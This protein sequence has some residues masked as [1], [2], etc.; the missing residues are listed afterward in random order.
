MTRAHPWTLTVLSASRPWSMLFS[1]LGLPHQLT[2]PSPRLHGHVK[3]Q[4]FPLFQ[5]C[6]PWKLEI[7][8][9]S[10]SNFL[11]CMPALHSPFFSCLPDSLK[12]LRAWDLQTQ[13][14]PVPQPIPAKA[15]RLRTAT[16]WVL[17]ALTSVWRASKDPLFSS[18]PP[19]PTPAPHWLGPW[20]RASAVAYRVS[21]LG[22]S[23]R[24]GP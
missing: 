4:V 8:L 14:Y 2:L 10:C 9:E 6:P 21:S 15:S 22:P 12:T 16:R 13:P 5:L 7:A 11:A 3:S 18:P 1:L 19:T 20:N 24:R 17:F 23:P